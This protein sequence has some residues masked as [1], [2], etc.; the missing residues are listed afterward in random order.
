MPAAARPRNSRR[1]GSGAPPAGGRAMT[2]IVG[3]AGEACAAES[4]AACREVEYAPRGTLAVRSPRLLTALAALGAAALALLVLP[5]ATREHAA[6]AQPAAP[7][8]ASGSTERGAADLQAPGA[9]PEASSGPDASP[10]PAPRA[11]LAVEPAPGLA[12]A[13]LAVLVV[14]E[15]TRAP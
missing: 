4:A 10:L 11:A 8:G 12:A 2:A 1:D 9:S 13:E 14:A 15:E 7:A 5:R 6:R 3:R